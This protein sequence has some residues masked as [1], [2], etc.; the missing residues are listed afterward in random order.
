MEKPVVAS[1]CTT[2]LKPEMRHIY[3][4]VVGLKRYDTFVMT[5]VNTTNTAALITRALKLTDDQA[6]T[7]MYL[8]VLSRY[9]TSAE[10]ATGVQNLKSAANATARTPS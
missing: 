10:L 3:R 8:E 9:P 2:F 1:Y 7:T 5:R 4:Q 6:V